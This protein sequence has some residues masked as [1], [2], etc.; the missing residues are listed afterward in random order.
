MQKERYFTPAT[1]HKKSRDMLASVAKYCRRHENIA[2]HPTRA[3]L[4]VLDMQEYFLSEASHAF[5]PSAPAIIPNIQFMLKVF[6]AYNRPIY[7]TRHVNTE[8]NAGMMGKWW[9]DLIC[10][11]T[12]YSHIVKQLDTAK[13]AILR[14]SQYDAFYETR[15]ESDLRAGGVGEVVITGVMTH[16]CCETTARSA[17]MRGFEVFF[18]MDG[19]ATYNESFHQATLLNL[20]HGFVIPVL[21]EEILAA[22]KDVGI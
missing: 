18:V 13:G 16:L 21:T 2:F 15:L 17:F 6:A 4:L 22:F 3:A 1:I 5:I 9:K 8:E 14:K 19:T 20:A 12:A 11:Q 10:P 7:F